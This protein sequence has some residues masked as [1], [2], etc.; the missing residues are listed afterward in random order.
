MKPTLAMVEAA[1]AAWN[2]AESEPGGRGPLVGSSFHATVT[3][4]LVAAAAVAPAPKCP[5]GYPNCAWTYS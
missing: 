5:S 3:E 4:M 2:D 1:I